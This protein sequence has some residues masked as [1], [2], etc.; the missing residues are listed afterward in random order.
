MDTRYA[1]EWGGTPVF[2]GSTRAFD[3]WGPIGNQND[4]TVNDC[5]V[6]GSA[7][8]VVIN[9]TAIPQTSGNGWL[10]V[11]PWGTSKPTA[12][13]VNY[14]INTEWSIAN[15]VV[16]KI[17]YGCGDDLYVYAQRTAHVLVDVIGY[18]ARNTATPL[19]SQQLVSSWVSCS[20]GAN[21][22]AEGPAC[23][24]GYTLTGGGIQ[25]MMFAAGQNNSYDAPHWTSPDPPDVDGRQCHRTDG[26]RA[27]DLRRLRDHHESTAH[28]PYAADVG[29]ERDLRHFGGWCDYHHGGFGG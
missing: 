22:T 12:S 4:G 10:T 21:C 13:L 3:V 28:A 23:S 1:T 26:V 9:V 11:W 5:G 6:P 16:Q 2:S 17:C 29:V 24:S 7:A 20:N 25:W 27:R 14:T 8:G 19:Q 15:A 18:F